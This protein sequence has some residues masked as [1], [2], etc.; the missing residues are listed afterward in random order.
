L[1]VPYVGTY[2]SQNWVKKNVLMMDDDTIENMQ[3]EIE[4]EPQPEQP[5]E[6]DQG[7][8]VQGQDQGQDQE[9][10]D[11]DQDTETDQS[12]DSES[13]TPELDAAVAKYAN[14]DPKKLRAV[15]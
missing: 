11:T 13:A 8:D 2:F 5:G 6:E 4:S 15:K 14:M 3:K 12:S 10:Q 9:P 7:Q 1:I